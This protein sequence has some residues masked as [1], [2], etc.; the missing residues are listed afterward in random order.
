MSQNLITVVLILEVSTLE[1][2]DIARRESSCSSNLK[3]NLRA[4]IRDQYVPGIRHIDICTEKTH[5]TTDT[6][7][8]NSHAKSPAP[9][10]GIANQT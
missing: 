7:S 5:A 6:P 1:F 2:D 4:P 9:L 8:Q 10:I 3:L